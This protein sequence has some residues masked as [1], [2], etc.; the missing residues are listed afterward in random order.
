MTEILTKKDFEKYRDEFVE[1]YKFYRE[2][3]KK[4]DNI[5]ADVLKK[6]DMV[7]KSDNKIAQQIFTSMFND[8][9]KL[10]SKYEKKIT[11]KKK[12]I[13]DL[14]NY[15]FTNKCDVT[16]KEAVKILKKILKY[17]KKIYKEMKKHEERLRKELDKWI[18]INK[19]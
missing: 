1:K 7:I 17:Q 14:L 10:I 11:F 19:K 12:Y 6:I 15:A 18:L 13:N 16:G 9:D 2:G 5:L 3:I 4:Y 8:N